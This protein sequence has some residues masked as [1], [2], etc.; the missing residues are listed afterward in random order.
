LRVSASDWSE[1]VAPAG[2]NDRCDGYPTIVG[3]PS[4]RQRPHLVVRGLMTDRWSC[5]TGR[6]QRPCRQQAFQWPQA[7]SAGS[8]SAQNQRGFSISCRTSYALAGGSR[9]HQCETTPAVCILAPPTESQSLRMLRGHPA[10]MLAGAPV[11]QREQR[12]EQQILG[13]R[14][15]G[16]H[17]RERRDGA[18]TDT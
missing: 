6:R 14:V 8:G 18:G 9:P 4:R 12:H 11:A 1:P 3:R 5:A 7:H 16:D 10:G 17:V 13:G 2:P 15:A